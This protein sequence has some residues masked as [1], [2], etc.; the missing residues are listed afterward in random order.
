MLSETPCYS[1]LVEN[2]AQGKKLLFDLGL[3][4]AWMEKLPSTGECDV[5]LCDHLVITDRW[6]L[7]LD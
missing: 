2:K 7:V 4:K 5:H 6:C 1:F 3:D